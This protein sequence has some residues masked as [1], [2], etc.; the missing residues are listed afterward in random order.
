[1]RMNRPIQG[2]WNHRANTAR[3]FLKAVTLSDV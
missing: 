1:M 2:W 3:A